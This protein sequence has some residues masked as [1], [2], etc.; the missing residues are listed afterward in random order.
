MQ[1]L[2]ER[3]IME[4]YLIAVGQG[5]D[6]HQQALW[7]CCPGWL[8]EGSYFSIVSLNE[9]SSLNAVKEVVVNFECTHQGCNHGI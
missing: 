8:H 7:T 3:L 1:I 5:V 2:P 6:H 9:C 4:S